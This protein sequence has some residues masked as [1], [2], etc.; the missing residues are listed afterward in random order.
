M[1][2]KL[3]LLCG[4]ALLGFTHAQ[5]PQIT[6]P[7]GPA[8]TGVPRK[9][10]KKRQDEFGRPEF[11]QA[12][13]APIGVDTNYLTEEDSTTKACLFLQTSLP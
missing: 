3:A 13:A 6:T 12:Y 11:H 7:P 4:A 5:Q 10:L 1:Y 9:P 2:R 8:T